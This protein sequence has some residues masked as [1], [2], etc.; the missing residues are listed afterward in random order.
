M[1]PYEKQ[2][3]FYF[4]RG[5]LIGFSKKK[6]TTLD[7]LKMLLKQFNKIGPELNIPAEDLVLKEDPRA[8]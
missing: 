4:T 3:W 7:D 8:V 2:I 5:Q 6:D 1:T